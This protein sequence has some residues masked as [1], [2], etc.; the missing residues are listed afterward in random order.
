[1]SMSHR[2]LSW[3]LVLGLLLV[4]PAAGAG[5][6]VPLSSSAGGK[7]VNVSVADQRADAIVLDYELQGFEL[8]PVEIAGRTYYQVRLAH[9]G[10]LLEAGLPELPVV[11]RSVIIPDQAAMDVRVV[12]ATYR[13]FENVDVVPSKGNLSRAVDPASVPYSFGATY[14]TDEWFPP[15]IASGRDP[16]ILRDFRGMTVVLEPVQYNAAQHTLRVY[17]HVQVE[18]VAVGPGSI[19]VLQRAAPP[20]VVNAEFAQLYKDRFINNAYYLYQPISEEGEML[21]IAYDNFV[22]NVV[23]FVDWKNQMGIRT[24]L[25]S[26]SEVG[27]TYQQFQ[28][29]IQDFYDTHDLAFVL[30]VGDLPQIP[31]PSNGGAPADPVYALVAG[32]DNYP[33][34]FVGRLC[35]ETPAQVDLQVQ[36]FVEYER[37]P[38]PAGNWYH[39]GMGIGSGQ[40][41]GI[42]DDG[43]ADWEHIENIRL[44]LLGF[45]YTGVDTIYEHS[46]YTASA[47]LVSAGVN[48]GRS[49]INYCGH[50][51]TN[52]WSTTGFSS[53]HIAQ[54]TN[55]DKL[56][57]IISVA[58]VNGAFQYSG[59]FAE[60]WMRATRDG[61][62]TG[63]VGI[64]ASTVN[65][66]W[67]PPMAAQD[68]SVDLL[69]A[70]QKRTFGALC[71]SGSC[72]MM[73]EYGS[74]GVSEFKNWHVFGDPS[75]RVRSDTPE[76][77]LVEHEDSIEPDATSFLVTVPGVTRAL[78]A[79]SKDGQFIGAAFTAASGQAVI[80]VEEP[81]PDDT[82]LLTVTYFNRLPYTAEIQVGTPLVP[83][84]LVT[85]AELHVA[86]GLE[87][88]VV[89][90]LYV[91]NVG[92]E[93]SVLSFHLSIG[94]ELPNPWLTITPDQGEVLAGEEQLV[95]VTFDTHGLSAGT[96]E[97]RII[98]ASNGGRVFV[99][100][101]LEA[102]DLA[103]VGERDLADRFALEPASPNPFAGV[104]TIGF[105]LPQ[106]SQARLGVYDMSGRL[107]RSLVS[108]S[109]TAGEH[110]LVWDG[111]D[112][113]GRE[114]SGGVYFYRLD[115]GR[116]SL[117]GRVMVLR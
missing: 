12:S 98:V 117:A 109:L 4:V 80:P 48:D 104:T 71:F 70:E 6:F 111:R 17:D 105:A 51:S 90:S 73:D 65:M 15:Q 40:G 61:Y 31:S 81:L 49:I 26:K 32:S 74:G 56:P 67:A 76:A 24:T 84:V 96:Y 21:V 103:A 2:S 11:A 101:A 78:C 35:A 112:D 114:V 115:A 43:E 62:P 42:G 8:D 10:H 38:D 72:Q 93:G 16:Y 86:M 116:E 102:G 34:I 14:A 45:T 20:Q 3:V 89:E 46:G 44:D 27:T 87:E 9:E 54:L 59:C 108:G 82:V 22:A 63:A 64:Y 91:E 99:P 75:L 53:S 50:G 106:A 95:E 85:P 37:D 100:V 66:S 113:G 92:M 36:K 18:V 25:V 7:I 5:T 69:V 13:D 83:A 39:R 107:V 97:T 58:C 79:L 94:S 28:S 30:L 110:H 33:D 29:Y 77:L 68:E 19:N 55:Y 88:T 52:A 60:S 41:A 57:W 47:A 23:P 1:M